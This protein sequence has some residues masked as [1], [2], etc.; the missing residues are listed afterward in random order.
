MLKKLWL[1]EGGAILSTE[2]ILIMVIL[3]IGLT[4]GMVALRD[5]V[6]EK[7]TELSAAVYAID[8]GYGWGGIL[9]Y[10]EADGGAVNAADCHAF[11]CGSYYAD[12]AVLAGAGATA[13]GVFDPVV[14][15]TSEPVDPGAPPAIISQ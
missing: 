3:V 11:V 7:L 6:V 15:L 12:S 13:G 9:Y 8:T 4:V 2:L 10:Q 5:A 1:D 14:V